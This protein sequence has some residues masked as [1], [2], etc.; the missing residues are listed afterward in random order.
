M[1]VVIP[2]ETLRRHRSCRAVYSS[3]YWNKAENAL[4]FPDWQDAVTN[5]FVPMGQE[6]FDRLEWHVRHKLVPM[7]LDEF[8]EL[9]KAHLN[10]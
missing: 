3:P 10:D 8:S 6:G 2:N 9:K 5:Y 1:R 7:T 4:V